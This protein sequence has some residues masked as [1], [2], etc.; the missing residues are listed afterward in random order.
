MPH[1]PPV[2]VICVVPAGTVL[3]KATFEAAI[4]LGLVTVIVRMLSAPTSTVVGENDAVI[5][6]ATTAGVAGPE[7]ETCCCVP[8]ALSE[9][10]VIV[11]APLTVPEALSEGEKVNDSKQL[12][13]NRSGEMEDVQSVPPE[14][15]C[16]KLVLT[17]SPV[18][19]RLWFPM[20]ATRTVCAALLVPPT[21]VGKRLGRRRCRDAPHHVVPEV[22][23]INVACRI[24]RYT[25]RIV[26]RRAGRRLGVAGPL[27]V[28]FPAIV[29]IV[30]LPSTR[31]TRA[32][33]R[34]PI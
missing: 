32:L 7:S 31:R 3:L 34:S 4:V 33:P 27:M 18:S 15:V 13:R 22:R 1:V 2:W 23:D 14:A 9:L 28:P 12:D 26:Q 6:R 29:E 24:D 10:S 30:P 17:A 21:V 8:G 25:Q 11:A 19:A 5:V 20:F 16:V